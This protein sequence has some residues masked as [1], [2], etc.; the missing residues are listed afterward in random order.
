MIDNT[1]Y[2]NLYRPRSLQELKGQDHINI[3][4]GAMLDKWQRGERAFPAALILTGPKGSGKTS[5]ARIIASFLNCTSDAEKPC[6]ACFSCQSIFDPQRSVD[7]VLEIDAAEKGKVEDI[8]ELK[9]LVNLAHS[10]QYR[11]IM[12]DE[13]H[14]A[15]SAAMS[16]FLKQLEEPPPGVLYILATTEF[17]QIPAT[18]ASRCITLQFYSVNPKHIYDRLVEVAEKERLQYEPEALKLIAVKADGAVRDALM[19]LDQL[20][21][22]DTITVAHFKQAFP[23]NPNEFARAFL[24][25]V[26][27]GDATKGIEVIHRYSLQ[28]RDV[29]AMTN[30][31]ASYLAAIITAKAPCPPGVSLIKLSELLSLI[32]D[33]KVKLRAATNHDPVLLELLWFTYVKCLGITIIQSE[34]MIEETAPPEETVEAHVEINSEGNEEEILKRLMHAT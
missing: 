14:A 4:V 24:E 1:R 12:L 20:S 15:S 17:Q 34:S 18:V 7:S 6:G 10:G 25:S 21:Y 8:R 11:V 27:S 2:A 19:L 3:I 31:V 16:A 32:W 5:T 9:S 33:L 28:Q 23:G 29:T 13:I 26:L 22:L 30:A